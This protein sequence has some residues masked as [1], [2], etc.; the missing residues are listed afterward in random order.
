MEV[1]L[2]VAMVDI[3]AEVAEEAFNNRNNNN[4]DKKEAPKSKSK[5]I[6]RR[7]KCETHN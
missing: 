6:T 2:E 7:G 1:S 4:K 3:A 5:T